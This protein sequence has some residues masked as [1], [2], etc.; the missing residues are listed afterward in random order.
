MSACCNACA[1]GMKCTPKCMDKLTES[2]GEAALA[3]GILR[4]VG[5]VPTLL[6]VP[7]KNPPMGDLLPDGA[8]ITAGLIPSF[9]LASIPVT[10]LPAS[11]PQA[12]SSVALTRI[13]ADMIQQG[14][15]FFLGTIAAWKSSSDGRSVG[16]QDSSADA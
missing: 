2:I 10:G 7:G 9:L 1:L 5:G 3:D 11:I 6:G 4:L 16:W 12:A 13:P 8:S 15:P 14:V